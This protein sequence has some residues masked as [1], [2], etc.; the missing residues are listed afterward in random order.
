[1]IQFNVEYN[2]RRE[3][4]LVQLTIICELVETT[5]HIL[6]QCPIASYLWMFFLLNI[7]G[8]FFRCLLGWSIS[9][10]SLNVL[11]VEVLDHM[12]GELRNVTFLC[13]YVLYGHSRIQEWRGLQRQDHGFPVGGH[14]QDDYAA[15][16]VETHSNQSPRLWRRQFL[17]SCTKVSSRR[18]V[19]L[20]K[21][22]CWCAMVTS[23][24]HG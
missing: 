1:M 8:C 21:V 14:T 11:F 15:Q 22:F 13:A 16:D 5:D 18:E 17:R 19:W 9:P 2:W 4:D 3:N 6:F 10:T 23:L 20:V 12:R 7:C 24:A